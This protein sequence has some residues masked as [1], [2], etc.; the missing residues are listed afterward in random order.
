VS[1]FLIAL[2]GPQER[3]LEAQAT[4]LE[5][6]PDRG[7]GIRDAKRA[8]Q[9][10]RATRQGPPVPPDTAGRGAWG[11]KA[12][13]LCLLLRRQTS[14]G[15]RGRG[16]PERLAPSFLGTAHPLADGAFAH[17]HGVSAIL[18]FP[19][20]LD[21]VPATEPTGFSPIAAAVSWEHPQASLMTRVLTEIEI[22][23]QGSVGMPHSLPR[24]RNGVDLPLS[25]R[26]SR[27][28]GAVEDSPLS[29]GRDGGRNAQDHS[30]EPVPR[31]E[32]QVVQH[33][34]WGSLSSS[35]T[36]RAEVNA[37]SRV[38]SNLGRKRRAPW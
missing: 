9:D 24:S 27:G 28:S 20:P 5:D 25:P 2:A 3:C 1:G 36:A 30:V 23:T 7:R 8:L 4:P 12:G 35:R 29:L 33:E 38:M 15:A 34:L 17:A 37:R 32:L 14:R 6:A 31:P 21:H 22:L 16:V 26:A 18:L 13:K 10:L 19:P 11:E